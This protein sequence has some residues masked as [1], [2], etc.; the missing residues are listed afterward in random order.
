MTGF[1]EHGNETTGS[2][3]QGQS[4]KTLNNVPRKILYR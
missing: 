2:V 3:Q 1:C 4:S